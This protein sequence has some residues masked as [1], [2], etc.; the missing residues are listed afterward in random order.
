MLKKI[1]KIKAPSAT[2]TKNK[3]NGSNMKNKD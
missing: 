1:A 3:I 2:R